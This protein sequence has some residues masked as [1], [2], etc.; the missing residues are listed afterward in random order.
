MLVRKYPAIRFV[1]HAGSWWDFISAD[2]TGAD[3]IPT[4]P[5]VPGGLTDRLLTDYPH[6]YADLSAGS[7]LHALTRDPDFTRE[8]IV[9]HRKKLMWGTDCPCDGTASDCF[10]KQSL[11]QLRMLTDSQERFDDVVHHNAERVVS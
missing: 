10:A 3:A 11:P 2:A 7:A 9:R 1:G 5:I 4:G 6:L 8:F